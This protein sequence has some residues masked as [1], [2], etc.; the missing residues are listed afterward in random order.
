M[1]QALQI[2]LTIAV[3]AVLVVIAATALRQE[4]EQNKPAYVLT[5]HDKQ[6][7]KRLAQTPP[8][9]YLEP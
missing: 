2:K 1:T 6:L 7:Q 9:T 5:E 8:K 3:L 4:R